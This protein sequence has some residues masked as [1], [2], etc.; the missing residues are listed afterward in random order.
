MQLDLGH[1]CFS[2]SGRV[3]PSCSEAELLQLS[4]GSAQRLLHAVFALPQRLLPSE[5]GRLALLPAPLLRLPR[6]KPLP[7]PKPETR[8]EAFAKLKGIE[9]RKRGRLVWDEPSQ[10]FAPRFGYQRAQQDGSE[11]AVII[12][13]KDAPRSSKTAGGSVQDPWSRLAEERTARRAKNERQRSRNAAAAAAPLRPAAGQR[14]AGTLDLAAAAAALPSSARRPLHH[15]DVALAVAQQ[16]TA[17]MGRFDPSRRGEPDV[18]S[19]RGRR[20]AKGRE[21][22]RKQAAVTAGR[23]E[24]ADSRKQERERQ[25]GLLSR[26]LDTADKAAGAEP[27]LDVDKAVSI[28]HKRRR[29][30]P[31]QPR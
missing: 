24:P 21:K 31:Q 12:E 30:Q 3:S 19:A 29:Q 28:V 7:A 20:E 5:P 27:G 4:S 10:A 22:V 25:L 23:D 18:S 13:E 2:D 14:V 6:A 8:W 16:S 26:L 9:K 15:V 1:L 17:S 11:Q